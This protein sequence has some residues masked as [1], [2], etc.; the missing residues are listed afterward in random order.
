MSIAEEW[1]KGALAMLADE[2]LERF[3]FDEI[4]GCITCL[5]CRQARSA[6]GTAP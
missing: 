5:A 1:G 2:L 6:P 3:P 4:Y